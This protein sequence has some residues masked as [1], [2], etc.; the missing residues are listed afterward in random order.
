MSA[1][2]MTP[3]GEVLRDLLSPVVAQMR[4]EAK[5]NAADQAMVNGERVVTRWADAIEHAIGG[6]GGEPAAPRPAATWVHAAGT[7]RERL[8]TVPDDTRLGVRELAEALGR[9]RSW[10]YRHTSK[11]SG[12][13]LLPHRRLDGDLMFV[14]REIRDW[15][16]THEDVV[17]HAGRIPFTNPTRRRA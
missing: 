6:K 7:W 4:E 16:Q 17:V 12:L 8:W 15:V 3:I 5:R 13:P 11:R 2:K 9:P 1:A 10:V 14:A